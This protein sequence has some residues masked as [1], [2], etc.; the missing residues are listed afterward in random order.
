M[1]LSDRNERE[2]L[3]LDQMMRALLRFAA[4]FH[5][6]VEFQTLNGQSMVIRMF[7]YGFEKAVELAAGAGNDCCG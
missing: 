1:K 5:Y 6:H 3:K 4:P 7:R 2:K